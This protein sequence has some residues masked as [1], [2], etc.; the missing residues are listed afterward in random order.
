METTSTVI[1]LAHSPLA[2][3]PSAIYCRLSG[4]GLPVVFLHGG[5]GY[6]IY[7]LRQQQMMEGCRMVIPDRSGYG[8]STKPAKFGRDFHHRAAQE[9]LLCLDQLGIEQCILW[10]H[11]DGAVIA[12]MV[13]L[14]QPARC[15]G[16]ILEA[17]HYDARKG[18][19]DF[20]RAMI[21]APDSFGHRATAAMAHEHG[22]PY[23]RE[24]LHAE[25][26]AWGEI[27]AAATD[28]HH[29]LYE[30]R[31]SWLSVP[32]III[33]GA[34]D[35]RT[36]PG[37]LDGI[38]RELPQSAFHLIEH[39]GHSPHSEPAS[40]AECTKIIVEAVKKWKADQSM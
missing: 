8:R 11:S 30:G 36:E 34:G 32:T 26:T 27:A 9:T 6:D 29:D 5:W 24:L 13:G 12:A 7:P 15:A 39:A 2:N 3:A 19:R 18:A 35:P 28:E 31:L 33:H 4:L 23:W 1:S 17:L 40:S 10:G 16:I 37:E 25:G 20:F 22:E 21:N 38:R 14:S